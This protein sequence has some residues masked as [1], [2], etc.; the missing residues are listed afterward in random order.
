MVGED[1]A[2]HLLARGDGQRRRVRR[3][4]H[5]NVV[6][7]IGREARAADRI[8]PGGAGGAGGGGEG[9]ASGRGGGLVLAGDKSGDGSRNSGPEV[10]LTTGSSIGFSADTCSNSDGAMALLFLGRIS[11]FSSM[12]GN[13]RRRSASVPRIVLRFL[14]TNAL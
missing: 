1:R 2:R 11:P 3:R 12:A 7:E 4:L 9:E 14:R 10:S 13:Q 5:E 8:A 6:A